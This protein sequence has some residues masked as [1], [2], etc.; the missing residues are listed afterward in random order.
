MVVES[1]NAAIDAI[2]TLHRSFARSSL[3]TPP[4]QSV[5]THPSLYSNSS[6]SNASISS[7]CNFTALQRRLSL[8]IRDSCN[9]F[10]G[11]RAPSSVL[12]D[13]KSVDWFH[14]FDSDASN[15]DYA[16]G[17]STVV[18]LIADLVSLPAEPGSVDLL[19]VLPPQLAAMYANLG[20]LILEPAFRRRAPRA[21]LAG[22]YSEYVKVIL[23]LRDRGMVAFTEKP[24]VVNGVFGVPKDG[25][26]S[27]RF[28]VDARP[29]NAMFV[30]P[31]AVS[32]PTPD[33]LASLITD[34]SRKLYA[35]K[36][37]LDN[38]YHRIRL[39][40]SLR[41]M[42][43]LPAVS[44]RD[45]GLETGDVNGMVWPMCTTLPM[46]WSH[47][48]F[49]A[50]A[51][52]EHI[53]NTRTH[54]SPAD[55]ITHHSDLVVDRVR[56]LVY[57]D[58][59]ILV[60]HD[61]GQ[62]TTLLTQYIDAIAGTGFIV[63]GKKVV[64]PTCDGL[65]CLGLEVDGVHHTVGLNADK[66]SLLQQAT[67]KLISGV[68][69]TGADLRRLVGKWTWAALAARP[70]FAVFNSVYRF[71]ETARAGRF[72]LWPSVIR[73]LQVMSALAPLL[74]STTSAEWF[75]KVVAVDAS[76]AGQGVVA[77]RPR[78]LRDGGP[79][80]NDVMGDPP[81]EFSPPPS[82]A[83]DAILSDAGP[84][85][86]GYGWSTI[87]SSRWRRG[88]HINVL[89]LRSLLTAVK[90]VLS[91]RAG[92]IQQRLLVLSD[93]AVVVGAVRKGRSSSQLLLRRLRQLSALLLASGLRLRIVW[94]PS[95]LNPADGASRLVSDV[96]Q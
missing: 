79:D 57:I 62:I 39:P 23:R 61:P 77:V 29:A 69:C 16:A 89:E 18:P 9:R 49:L 8:R 90:W 40:E 84:Y 82:P 93:S 68:T 56:H 31:Q 63:K 12:C 96:R 59:L 53:L 64:Q 11:R 83:L 32:L 50:Q 74:F 78:P 73:E 81:H 58:D 10:I 87:V 36:A 71:I 14:H 65:E 25:G 4:F 80:L 48:V 43:C 3:S 92:G 5:H 94:V 6:S 30:E 47:S 95:E 42:F 51:I 2:N 67:V 7:D 70:A 34:P 24:I 37:D 46:G 27:I 22:S 17:T 38:F 55:R 20:N 75:Q 88:E 41:P 52:H 21:S 15:F 13:S 45:V 33:L 1:S 72:V 44:A 85:G 54:L 60:G 91:H 35:A 28:I 19:E 86:S 26:A 66:L 76:L